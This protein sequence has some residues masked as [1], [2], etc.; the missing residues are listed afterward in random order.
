MDNGNEKCYDL[1]ENI[2][3]YNSIKLLLEKITSKHS[4]KDSLNIFTKINESIPKEFISSI[5]SKELG[6]KRVFDDDF[7]IF[8]SKYNNSIEEFEKLLTYI[9][10]TKMMY[11]KKVDKQNIDLLLEVIDIGELKDRYSEL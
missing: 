8:L 5:L 7:Y 11:S 6:K 2:V 3:D 10:N 9:L 4:L 1:I